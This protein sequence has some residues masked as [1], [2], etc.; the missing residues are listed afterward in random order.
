MP[1]ETGLESRCAI[2]IKAVAY[3]EAAADYRVRPHTQT[4][5]QWYVVLAGGV[6]MTVDDELFT[7]R[8]LESIL[9]PPGAIRSPAM[10]GLPPKYLWCVFDN[11]R[12]H[13]DRLERRVLGIPEPLRVDLEDLVGEL[14]QV[15]RLD[16]DALVEALVVRLLIGVQRLNTSPGQGPT[17]SLAEPDAYRRNVVKRA[18]VFMGRNLHRP[19][20]RAEIA[21]AAGV[22]EPHLARLFRQVTG[23]T[24][25]QRLTQM[26]VLFA[27]QLLV[28]SSLPVSEVAF[29]VGYSSASHFN[30]VFRRATGR[31]PSEYRASASR[32][33]G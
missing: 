11:E 32:S 1:K 19:L 10:H 12:L 24:L 9:I 21:A 27:K 28:G 26:R 17:A 18:G 15:P 13:L 4:T 6:D 22:S 25:V 3:R 8:P 23:E 29:E 5:H 20:T 7:L 31:T 16:S 14:K 30:V 2:V 33:Q